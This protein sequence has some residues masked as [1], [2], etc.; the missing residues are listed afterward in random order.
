MNIGSVVPPCPAPAAPVQGA[1]VG[2]L[3]AA[4]FSGAVVAALITACIAILLARRK[5]REEERL[6]FVT[7]SPTRYE[8]KRHT[9]SSP[10]PY[11]GGPRSDRWM[12][13]RALQKHSARSSL[14]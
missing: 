9:K 8:R 13:E 7:P 10:T 4:V 2:L 12:S 1:G 14:S 11:E 3:L 5:S 6:D